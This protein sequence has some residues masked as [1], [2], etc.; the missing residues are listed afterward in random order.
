MLRVIIK[1]C[2]EA[3]TVQR[4]YDIMLCCFF[5][6][7]KHHYVIIN[8]SKR[9]RKSRNRSKKCCHFSDLRP[10][11]NGFS[12]YF[13]A[14]RVLFFLRTLMTP[15]V[16]GERSDSHASVLRIVSTQKYLAWISWL[17]MAVL[18]HC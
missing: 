16:V 2:E 7:W 15:N 12:W 4:Q 8:C 6:V 9:Q 18:V 13:K 14:L 3:D 10:K 5:V 11:R 17:I 1:L